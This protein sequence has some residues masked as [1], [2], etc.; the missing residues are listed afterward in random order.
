MRAIKTIGINSNQPV[1][2]GF[3]F[4]YDLAVL[5]DGNDN[6][7]IY[8]INRSASASSTGTRIQYFTFDEKWLGEFGNSD[9]GGDMGF[10]RPVCVA[11]DEF[12]NL[13]VTDEATDEIKVFTKDGQFCRKIGLHNIGLDDLGENLRFGPSGIYID[14]EGNIT[15]ASRH[16]NQVVK[17]TGQGFL[18][19][20]FGSA[21]AE[22]GQFN[23]PWG[24]TIDAQEC[25][26][27]A[28]WRND[29]IQKFDQNGD[30]IGSF[31]KPGNEAGKL[32]RP[33]SVAVDDGGFIA[34]ADWGN[35]RVQIFGQDGSVQEILY[36]D[37]TLSQWSKEWLDV[38][39]DEKEARDSSDLKNLELP[40]HLKN[41]YHTASQTEHRFWG[42]VSVKYDSIGRL[43]VTEHSRH[44]VQVFGL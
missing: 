40:N 9:S 33:S 12:H 22:P 36:G 8:L 37:A 30:Y 6:P 17:I 29:R 28:D 26:Y 34:V 15:V 42:P 13:Y 4:P 20:S 43:Y 25:V 23:M 39:L 11:F 16:R 38:N 32:S 7:N 24:V 2:R 35:E 3:N 18:L 5:E 21:G 44:R 27:V 10:V 1:G 14:A 31:G 19:D 41:N